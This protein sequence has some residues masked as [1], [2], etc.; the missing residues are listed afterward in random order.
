LPT[1]M[2]S[3]RNTQHVLVQSPEKSLISFDFQ[4]G[5]KHI[6]NIMAP[7]LKRR[8]TKTMGGVQN[9]LKFFAETGKRA[10]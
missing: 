9:D 1:F 10:G 2:S 3:A 5:L 7:L 8:F 4:I 6:F